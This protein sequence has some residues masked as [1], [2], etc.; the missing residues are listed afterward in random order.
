MESI[1]DADALGSS[2]LGAALLSLSEQKMGGMG[3][4]ERV[5]FGLISVSPTTGE[6]VYDEFTDTAMRSELETRLA[7]I[8]PFELLLPASKLSKHTERMLAYYAENGNVRVER[9]NDEMDYTAGFEF[10]RKF[11]EEEKEEI[12]T[13]SSTFKKREYIIPKS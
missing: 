11:Y 6:V 4:D 1:D 5:K 2:S 10:L 7:H 12:V 3:A 13:T 9:V 8:K